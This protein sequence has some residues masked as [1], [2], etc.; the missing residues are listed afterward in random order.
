MSWKIQV[1]LRLPP[2]CKIFDRHTLLSPGLKSDGILKLTDKPYNLLNELVKKLNCYTK[3][4]ILNLEL[5]KLW[6]GT[7][8]QVGMI[9]SY[10]LV[11]NRRVCLR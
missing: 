4:R 2:A 6:F 1:I 5:H 7:I 8:I 10:C 11:E 3:F 9:R